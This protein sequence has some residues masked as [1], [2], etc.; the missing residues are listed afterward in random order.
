VIEAAGDAV[1]QDLAHGRAGFYLLG[2]EAVHLGIALVAH[3][4][5]LVG[6]E[7][8]Q[9]LPHVV[10]GGIELLVLLGQARVELL[11]L[12]DVLVRAHHAAIGH[13]QAHDRDG[14]A[15]DQLD[16]LA[17]L[18]IEAG[19]AIGDELCRID[20]RV[21]AG[22][23]ARLQNLAQRCPGLHL[24]MREP[25]DL[26]IAAVGDHHALVGVE[27]AQAL[28]HV[29]DG[30]IDAG[31]LGG[32]LRLALLQETVLLLE[33][34]RELFPFGDVLMGRNPS[35]I[36]PRPDRD[37]D[38]APVAHA[39]RHVADLLARHALAHASQHLLGRGADVVTAGDALLDDVPQRCAGLHL[40]RGLAV[41]LREAVVG[42]HHA[43]LGVEHGKPLKHVREGRVQLGVLRLQVFLVLQQQRALAL[44]LLCRR[45]P[46]AQIAD[47]V[48][49]EAL[50]PRAERLAGDLDGNCRT[51]GRP[52]FRLPALV[53]TTARWRH[54][55]QE[56]GK[57]LADQLT[58]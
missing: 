45:L 19:N 58:R 28:R 1:L 37:G 42:D 3:D 46:P 11:A 50:E 15:V 26:G 17:N 22:G 18:L 43:L 55:R 16:D 35:P 12:G 44:Q 24:G 34:R 41:H 47:G 7:H 31:I 51:R 8:G 57:A 25:V 10:Q 53:G 9:A 13:R 52:Q 38:G 48:D 49:V 20:P 40:V 32:Q 27:Q 21:D 30:R 39:R 6:I 56:V 23:G 36:G 5:P 4:Q 14:A 33:L 54:P 2:R 29:V